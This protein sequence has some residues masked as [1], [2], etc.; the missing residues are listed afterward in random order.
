MESLIDIILEGFLKFLNSYGIRIRRPKVSVFLLGILGLIFFVWLSSGI[1]QVKEGSGGVVMRFGRFVRIAGPGLNYHLPFPF[2]NVIQEKVA[3]SRRVEIGYRSNLE[4]G[5]KYVPE[6]S[7]I[8]TSD[9]NIVRLKCDVTWHIEDL[10]AFVFRVRDTDSSIRHIAQSAV[11]EVI[12][13]TPISDIL[14]NKKQEIGNKIEVLTQRIVD[15]YGAG[16]RIEKVHL[17]AAEPPSDVIDAYRDVQSSRADKEREINQAQAYWNDTVTRAKG[18]V[19]KIV[20]N[21]EGLS[22]ESVSHALGDTKRFN[23]I[24]AQ[25]R[26]SKDITKRRMYLEV[27]EKLLAGNKKTILEGGSLPHLPLNGSLN[28]KKDAFISQQPRQGD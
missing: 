15:H 1:F 7:N 24:L 17:L 28:K 8:L 9:E 16:I 11:R 22:Q 5:L 3:Y 12:S 25:Y 4:G 20:Q 2:E 26:L 23:E 27:M 13:E 6:E 21:A 18:E 10:P 14:S 19:M